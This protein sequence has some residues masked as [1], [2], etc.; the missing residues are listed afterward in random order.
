MNESFSDQHQ[1]TPSPAP[2]PADSAWLFPENTFKDIR[3]D[4]H[5]GVIVERILERGNRE[6][7]SWL[8]RTYGEEDVA[9]WVRQ[10][11]YRSLTRRSF[12]LWRLALDVQ[13]YVAPA[14]A[15]EAK[16]YGIW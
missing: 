14:W 13:D 2:L 3:L 8:F 5:H 11:G 15:R 12:A 10:H 9:R 4:T 16:T 7:V 1:G 6:Q